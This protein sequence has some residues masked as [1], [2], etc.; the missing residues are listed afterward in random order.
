MNLKELQESFQR[1]ILKDDDE[2]LASLKDGEAEDRKVLFGVYRHA[3]SARLVEVLADDYKGLRLH[4]GEQGFAALAKSYIAAF[5][6]DR[7]SVRD[8]G[9]YLPDYLRTAPEQASHPESAEMA[10]LEKV[11]LDAFD[12]PEAAPLRLS[13]LADISAELWPRLIFL[14]HPTVRRLSLNTNAAEIW[15]ALQQGSESPPAEALT[16]PQALVVWREEVTARFRVMAAEEAMMWDEAA[17][18]TR[19]GVLCEMVAA[20]GG[21]DDAAL[22]A[23]SYLKNWA[24]TG[25]LAGCRIG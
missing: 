17:K 20:F 4:L 18:R 21:E 7:R 25:M 15:A 5:P 3:Y 12:G 9:R 13:E 16:E 11:L 1:G 10:S 22:R 23:A 8:F 14:P 19:F 2:I 24:D 6:S